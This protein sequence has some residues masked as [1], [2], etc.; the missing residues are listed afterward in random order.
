MFC[1]G[2]K[3]FYTLLLLLL[4]H[5]MLLAKKSKFTL[6]DLLTY[7]GGGYEGSPVCVFLFS[8]IFIPSKN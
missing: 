6:S 5:I 1:F 2:R 8:S 7:E 3:P 4:I